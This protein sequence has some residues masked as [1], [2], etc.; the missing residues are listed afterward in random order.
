MVLPAHILLPMP[1]PKHVPVW[2]GPAPQQGTPR[3]SRELR[4]SRALRT[5][6][7]KGV[8]SSPPPEEHPPD[9]HAE[10]RLPAP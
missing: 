3:A 9:E 5:R 10:L 6:R 1:P 2:E 7:E 4:G 8:G